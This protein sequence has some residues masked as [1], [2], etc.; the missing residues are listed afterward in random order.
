MSRPHCA[1]GADGAVL[2]APPTALTL[3][4]ARIQSPALCSLVLG[5]C[6]SVLQYVFPTGFV[7][8]TA[9]QGRLTSVADLLRLRAAALAAS[10]WG[11]RCRQALSFPTPLQGNWSCLI[12]LQT[13]P[14]AQPLRP[15]V[16]DAG[17]FCLQGGNH[18]LQLQTEPLTY[19]RTQAWLPS[20]PGAGN[21]EPARVQINPRR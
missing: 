20:S 9:L 4:L 7:C 3:C 17:R 12:L 13:E 15:R 14:S 11:G 8:A 1:A 5:K 6:L 16:A 18:F 10:P 19:H 2:L 21:R